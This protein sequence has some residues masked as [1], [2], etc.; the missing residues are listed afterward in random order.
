[1]AENRNDRQRAA[2]SG[3]DVAA[4]RDDGTYR[5]TI[6]IVRNIMVCIFAFCLN[7]AVCGQSMYACGCVCVCVYIWRVCIFGVC[8]YICEYVYIIH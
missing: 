3:Q 5:D 4:N 6:D 1:M 7:F 8:V 2:G